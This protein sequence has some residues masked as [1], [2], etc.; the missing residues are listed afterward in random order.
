MIGQFQPVLMVSFGR[1]GTPEYIAPNRSLGSGRSRGHGTDAASLPGKRCEQLFKAVKINGLREIRVYS[2]LECAAFI[3]C[4]AAHTDEKTAI[5]IELFA[6][7]SADAV[8][9]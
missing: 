4:V 1:C 5:A 6:H 3:F 8:A 2:G 7:G 9:V